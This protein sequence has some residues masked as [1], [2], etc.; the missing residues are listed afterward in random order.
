MKSI[1][2]KR[3]KATV[4]GLKQIDKLIGDIDSRYFYFISL[5]VLQGLCYNLSVERY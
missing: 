3:L 5:N 4:S 2:W 1:F